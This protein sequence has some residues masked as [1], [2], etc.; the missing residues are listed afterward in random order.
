MNKYEGFFNINL[1]SS[2]FYPTEEKSI[3]EIIESLIADDNF[4]YQWKH[5]KEPSP[6]D[7]SGEEFNLP[8]GH[9]NSNGCKYV[10]E[11]VMNDTKNWY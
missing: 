1:E 3:H 9:W 5:E 10:A 8:C 2:G 7:A 6:P 11:H 4:I